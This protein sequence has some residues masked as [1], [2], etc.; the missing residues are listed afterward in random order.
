MVGI[1]NTL[2][3]FAFSRFRQRLSAPLERPE[4]PAVEAPLGVEAHPTAASP[5]LVMKKSADVVPL[6]GVT[7]T[8]TAESLPSVPPPTPVAAPAAPEAPAL[9]HGA[10]AFV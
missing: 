6:P 1:L 8:P 9:S 7:P 3:L 2:H 5:E 10:F 4:I